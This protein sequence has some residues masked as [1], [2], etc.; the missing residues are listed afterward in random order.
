MARGLLSLVQVG[1][2]LY[3]NMNLLK[4]SQRASRSRSALF[5]GVAIL[6]AVS[7]VAGPIKANNGNGGNPAPPP[8][9]VPTV[10]LTPAGPNKGDVIG[11][12]GGTA[13]FSDHFLQPT[14]TGVFKPFLDLKAPDNEK[15]ERAFNTDGNVGVSNL[16]LDQHRQQWNN[17][18]RFG[19][20][21][22]FNIDGKRYFAF[23]LDANEP[24]NKAD[25]TY[26]GEASLISI[27]NFHVYTSS[28]ITTGLVQDDESKL[29][30]LGNLRWAMNNPARTGGTANDG[31]DIDKWV[32]L[33]SSQE[34]LDVGDDGPNPGANGGSG[35]ADM[36]V[37]V[38][39]TAFSGVLQPI[40][41][42]CTT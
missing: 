29:H 36:V 17:L 20:L 31:Y 27:D 2:I 10:D 13:I 28:T 19:D 33:E 39:A 18:L 5:G 37:Y 9:P 24:G 11:D 42:G 22:D 23:V 32:K 15:F 35:M 12:V 4:S 7:L 26:P 1:T 30:L 38:P 41:F 25:P 8:A 21:A 40:M 3:L 34:N 14:G 16:Y 6:S